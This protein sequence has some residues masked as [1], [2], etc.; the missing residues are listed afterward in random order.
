MEGV[1][2]WFLTGTL[3]CSWWSFQ[4]SNFALKF[5]DQQVNAG[6]NHIQTSGTIGYR[7]WPMRRKKKYKN[8]SSLE[9]YERFIV[10]GT[11]SSPPQVIKLPYM[12]HA[13][14]SIFLQEKVTTIYCVPTISQVL[15]KM[16]NSSSYKCYQ[17]YPHYID[18]NTEILNSNLR[19]VTK[20]NMNPK[21]HSTSTIPDCLPLTGECWC[22]L[23]LGNIG[24]TRK[25]CC[26]CNLKRKQLIW[27]CQQ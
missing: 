17:Y 14:V 8:D 21:A 4:C 13:S 6:G 1:G 20:F 19:K 25:Q 9:I 26:T 11:K 24:A 15:Y 10:K 3:Y 7:V 18:E 27:N 2:G 16:S 5:L 22:L 23:N 12:T